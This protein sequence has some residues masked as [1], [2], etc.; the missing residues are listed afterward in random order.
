ML[1]KIILF[2]F[3]M[4]L[5]EKNLRDFILAKISVNFLKRLIKHLES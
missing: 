5:L 1:V 2:P 3:S 4:I